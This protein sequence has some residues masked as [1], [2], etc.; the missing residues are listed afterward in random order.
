MFWS[1]QGGRAVS[2]A[3]V[4]VFTFVEVGHTAASLKRGR[5]YAGPEAKL[6]DEFVVFVGTKEMEEQI[7][8]RETEEEL[9][10]AGLTVR[11]KWQSDRLLHP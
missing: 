1:R 7:T 4:H 5:K 2:V 10:A 9:A 6:G 11:G 8:G 3:C